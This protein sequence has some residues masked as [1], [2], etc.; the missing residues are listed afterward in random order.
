VRKIWGAIAVCGLLGC[1]RNVRLVSAHT[2][3]GARYLCTPSACTAATTIDPAHA[4][5]RGTVLFRLPDECARVHEVLVLDAQQKEPRVEVTC[6]P[7]E[8]G[9]GGMQ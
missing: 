9:L 5:A 6:A 4:N 3:P 2:S 8:G 1:T 7:P